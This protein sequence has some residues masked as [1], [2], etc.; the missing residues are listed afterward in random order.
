M[1]DPITLL[2]RLG[3]GNAR[4]QARTIVD[5]HELNV[6]EFDQRWVPGFEELSVP[7]WLRVCD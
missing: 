6:R 1:V 2:N 7:T 3:S 4:G 5:F